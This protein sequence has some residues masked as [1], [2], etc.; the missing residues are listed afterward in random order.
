MDTKSLKQNFESAL[1]HKKILLWSNAGLVILV[2]FLAI[3]VSSKKE[4]LVLVPA[5]LHEQ[6]ELAFTEAQ[7]SYKRPFALSTSL[8]IGNVN[9]GNAEWVADKLSVLFAPNLY[10]D[11]RNK[12]LEEAEYLKTSGKAYRFIPGRLM[13]ERET[14]L[15]FVPGEQIIESI[16]NNESKVEVT[17]EF[18]I[19]IKDGLPQIVHY[20]RYEGGPRTVTWHRNEQRRRKRAELEQSR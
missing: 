7:E 13:Y 14:E 12:I 20:D 6:A 4:R 11:L 2:F 3:S 1:T 8:L 9:S 15:F 5:H 10:R 19:I 17:Y 16:N 18:K